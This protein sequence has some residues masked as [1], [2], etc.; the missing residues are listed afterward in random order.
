MHPNIPEHDGDLGQE[1][2]S[3]FFPSAPDCAG[4]NAKIYA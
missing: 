1:L 4:I 2:F 3:P